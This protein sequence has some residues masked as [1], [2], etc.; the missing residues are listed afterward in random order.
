VYG[1][2]GF[3]LAGNQLHQLG[4]RRNNATSEEVP[5]KVPGWFVHPG[6]SIGG[7]QLA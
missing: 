5:A 1:V 2:G 6:V 3:L 7:Q 4:V